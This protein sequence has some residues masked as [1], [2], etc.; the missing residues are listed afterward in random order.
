MSENGTLAYTSPAAETKTE[1]VW[2]NRQGLAYPVSSSLPQGAM[3]GPEISPDGRRMAFLQGDG[4]WTFDFE[5]EVPALLVSDPTIEPPVWTPD[6]HRLAYTRQGSV[7]WRP[8]DGSGPEE[9]LAR[10]DNTGRRGT[11]YPISWSPDGRVLAL[12]DID[13]FTFFDRK[14]LLF[15]LDTRTLRPFL[16]EQFHSQ[17]AAMFSPD[18]HWIAY[19]SDESGRWEVRVAAYPQPGPQFQISNEGGAEPRWSRDGRELFYRNGQKMMEV[20][21]TTQPAFNASRPRLLFEGYENAKG[22]DAN[23]DVSPDGKEFL[24]IR[25]TGSAPPGQIHVVLNWF[26][27]LKKVLTSEK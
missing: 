21:I 20:R 1:A 5:R 23:Y 10:P 2:V 3:A 11:Q 4:I 19:V 6:G 9:R 16:Q 25:A 14:I 17:V 26:E 15:S 12:T 7:Y 24:M 18:G 8:V 27:G 13:L 22:R